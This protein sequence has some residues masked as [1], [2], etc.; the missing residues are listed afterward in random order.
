MAYRVPEPKIFA[1]T[2]SV[3]LGEKIA[4]SYGADLGKV[5]FS[6]YSDGE[7][8]P[9]FEESIRGARIFIII[10]E[11]KPRPQCVSTR[12]IFFSVSGL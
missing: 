7:F 2:Q 5:K 11:T 1:C 10:A 9:S 12:V 8:Q 4:A 3:A 6:R